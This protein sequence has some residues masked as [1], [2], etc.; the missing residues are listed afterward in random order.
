MRIGWIA[1]WYRSVE[2]LAFG[3]ALERCRF[4]YL[5]RVAAARRVLIL[6]EGDGRTLGR[7]LP[8]APAARFDVIELS[9]EMIALARRR[10]RNS[11]RV[12]FYCRDARTAGWTPSSYDAI[13]TNFFLDCLNEQDAAGVIRRLANSL[14]R[15]G[16]W[17]VSEFAI[18]PGGWRRLHAQIWI[19]AMYLFFRATTGLRTGAL[20]PIESLMRE[21]G[22]Q[23]I[24]RRTQRAGMIVSELWRRT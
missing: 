24:E 4:A 3:H 1:P 9:R 18:P 22:M 11:D 19:R 21:A 16:I 2:Y 15:E 5:T 8:L 12:A 23:C 17:L 13:V 7:L 20:P 6:G 10:T 14:S